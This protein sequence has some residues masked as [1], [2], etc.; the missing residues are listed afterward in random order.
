MPVA[1]HLRC[2]CP[3]RTVRMPEHLDSRGNSTRESGLL[4]ACAVLGG[5][6]DSGQ[7]DVLCRN[8]ADAVGAEPPVNRSSNPCG[9]LS[10]AKQSA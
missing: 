3:R 10:S 9:A 8:G 4:A 1:V 2:P 7:G 6:I 5:R